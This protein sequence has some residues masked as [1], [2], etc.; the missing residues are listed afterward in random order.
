MNPRTLT[1]TLRIAAV[2]VVMALGARPAAAQYVPVDFSQQTFAAMNLSASFTLDQAALQR[3]GGRGERPK[4]RAA[5][6]VTTGRSNAAERLAAAYPEHLRG[7]ARRSLGALLTAYAQV[8]KSL[9]V[10]RGDA[11]GS[12]A[13]LLV[14]SFEAYRDATVDSRHYEGLMNQLRAA[15]A[16]DARFGKASPAARREVYEQTAILGMLVAVTRANLARKPDPDTARRL[17]DAARGYLV[18]LSL[19]PDA[20]QIDERGLSVASAAAAP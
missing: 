3:G 14:A 16:S 19:D 8:E 2:A 6:T 4:A 11:A 15:L 12:V 1:W 13:L 10:P 9:G 5:S 17:R 7:E 20:I 18:E